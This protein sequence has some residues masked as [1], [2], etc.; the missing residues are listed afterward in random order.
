MRSSAWVGSFLDGIN[1]ASLSLMTAVT[2]QLGI[3]SLFDF[4]T[5]LIALISLGLLLRFKFN[6]TW[7]VAGGA[8]AGLLIQLFR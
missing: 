4:P 1:I 8:L 5:I 3:S 6:P 2:F 7:L